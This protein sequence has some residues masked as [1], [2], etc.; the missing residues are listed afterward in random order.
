MNRVYY[1][2]GSQHKGYGK[3]GIGIVRD[4]AEY[5][6]STREFDH[7]KCTHEI[8]AIRKTIEIAIKDGFNDIVV[9]NDDRGLVRKIQEIKQDRKI[10]S[11]ALKKK[12]NSRV[13]LS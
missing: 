9:I 11:R 8:E 1:C 13:W 2:D 7:D 5:H 12:R 10:T 4:D 6:F 3:L